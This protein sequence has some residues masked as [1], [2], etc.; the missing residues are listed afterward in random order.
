MKV[1]LL[2]NLGLLSQPDQLARQVA[3]SSSL[4]QATEL[5]SFRT[6]LHPTGCALLSLPLALSGRDEIVTW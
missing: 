3:S 5:L 4:L 2:S 1:S 6:L